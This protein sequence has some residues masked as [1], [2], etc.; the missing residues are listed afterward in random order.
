MRVRKLI[1]LSLVVLLL[2]GCRSFGDGLVNTGRS[3]LRSLSGTSIGQV[4]VGGS[5]IEYLERDAAGPTLVMLHGFASEKDSWLRFMRKMPRQYR[6]LALDLP[7]HGGSSRDPQFDYNIENIVELVDLAIEELADEPV[8][9]AGS[10]LGGMVATLLAA[11]HPA[12]VASLALYAPAGVYPREPSKF[13]QALARG[14]NPLIATTP[15]EFERL[16]DMVFYDPPPLMWPVGPSIRRYAISRAPF[17][18]KIWAD[19]WPGHPTVNELLPAID[20]PVLLVWGSEDEILDVSSV[21]I[22]QQLLPQ[23]ETVVVNELGHATINERP[24]AMAR[25]QRDFLASLQDGTDYGSR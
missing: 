2:A 17:H 21:E 4:T 20:K 25:L 23:V 24:A 19:L 11:R 15:E 14:E 8:H 18:R 12:E 6:L 7:G 16:M 3:A 5:T 13:Q 9:I 10:S 22:Y 1:T